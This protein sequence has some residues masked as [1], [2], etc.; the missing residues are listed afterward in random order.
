VNEFGIAPDS[1]LLVLRKL[2]CCFAMTV[3]TILTRSII[4]VTNNN[5]YEIVRI[6]AFI[7]LYATP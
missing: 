1:F 6:I 7:M 3:I 5:L 2:V 4:V